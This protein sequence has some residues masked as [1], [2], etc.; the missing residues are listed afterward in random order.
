MKWIVFVMKQSVS[1]NLYH[2]YDIDT[3][4]TKK[5]ALLPGW[6]NEFSKW[7]NNLISF[8]F[9]IKMTTESSFITSGLV[10]SCALIWSG[11]CEIQRT[12]SIIGQCRSLPIKIVLLNPML[13]NSSQYQSMLEELI[14]VGWQWSTLQGISDQCQNFDRHWSAIGNDQGSPVFMIGAK[15]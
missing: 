3:N 1:T 7:Q 6:V 11:Q 8:A 10:Q 5:L 12:L 4:S 14:G 13:I 2:Y 9:S 15:I